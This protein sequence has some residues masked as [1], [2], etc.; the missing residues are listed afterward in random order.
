M[1]EKERAREEF[2]QD[3]RRRS[4]EAQE[5]LRQHMENWRKTKYKSS[6]TKPL[7]PEMEQCLRE[8]YK[9]RSMD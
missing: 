9:D 2:W 8:I 5:R 6:E 1:T 3:V 4:R 7:T